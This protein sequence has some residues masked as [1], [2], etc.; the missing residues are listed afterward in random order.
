MLRR[1]LVLLLLAAVACAQDLSEQTLPKW[2]EY[3][4]PSPDELKWREVPW[5]TVFWDAVVEA[6]REG[7]PLLIWAMNGHPLGCT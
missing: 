5:R 2:L 6:A 1:L 7:K 4:S 3:I